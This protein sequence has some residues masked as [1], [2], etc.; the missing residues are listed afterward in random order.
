ME[1]GSNELEKEM[2]SI[3][4]EIL[5]PFLTPQIFFF[6]E[7]LYHPEKIKEENSEDE[8]KED[9]D[10]VVGKAPIQQGNIVT[11]RKAHQALEEGEIQEEK[12][13]RK[14]RRKSHKEKR[15]ETTNMD[16]ARGT[17]QTI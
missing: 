16:K 3:I 4:R 2:Y 13:T 17:K 8:R 7:Q 12:S 1:S 14:V 6:P 11:R 10:T 5:E 9:H 15:E